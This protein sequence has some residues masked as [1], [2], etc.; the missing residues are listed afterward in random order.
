[1]SRRHIRGHR[2]LSGGLGLQ[3]TAATQLRQRCSPAYERSRSL[4]WRRLIHTRVTENQ[5][6]Q[7]SVSTLRVSTM[8]RWS[9]RRSLARKAATKYVC[10]NIMA[11]MQLLFFP[12]L[13]S[14]FLSLRYGVLTE[15]F[16]C[17]L[18]TART[19]SRL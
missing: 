4:E 14:R 10:D 8:P 6:D 1:M 7:E 18:E 2:K 17:L 15:I 3:E 5:G 13:P 9:L 12:T 19:Q 16:F 11:V